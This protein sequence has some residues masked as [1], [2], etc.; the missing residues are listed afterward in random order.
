LKISIDK[1]F[2]KNKI[3]EMREFVKHFEVHPA[4]A[5]RRK[6]G[7][8]NSPQRKLLGRNAKEE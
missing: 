7:K 6:K 5:I 2:F 8:A 3:D 4:S 1:E